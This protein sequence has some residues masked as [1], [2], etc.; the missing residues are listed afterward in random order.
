MKLLVSVE[1][2]HIILQLSIPKHTSHEWE[3]FETRAILCSFYK[4]DDF[5]KNFPIDQR[6]LLLNSIATVYITIYFQLFLFCIQE[7]SQNLQSNIFG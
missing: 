6:I 1:R 2:G 3:N 7:L 5:I 4:P